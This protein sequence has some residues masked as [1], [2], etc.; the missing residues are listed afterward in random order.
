MCSLQYRL[1][2]GI[3]C[4]ACSAVD[5]CVKYSLHYGDMC[6]VQFASWSTV[7]SVQC[8]VKCSVS[9]AVTEHTSELTT[10]EQLH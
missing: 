6:A 2:Y 8:A 1:L 9:H 3:M 7:C 5:N 4:A 10:S